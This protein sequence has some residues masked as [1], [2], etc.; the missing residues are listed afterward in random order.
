VFSATPVAVTG[1]P[2]YG[3]AVG[4]SHTC[5]L[6][7]WFGA[8]CWGRNDGGQLGN[9]LTTPLSSPT[10]VGLKSP[11]DAPLYPVTPKTDLERIQGVLGAAHPAFHL[12][13]A[14]LVTTGNETR[15][16]VDPDFQLL[17]LDGHELQAGTTL[18]HIPARALNPNWPARGQ[19][20][21]YRRFV[22]NAP[23]SDGWGANAFEWG[24]VPTL[25]LARES[26]VQTF[27]SAP[28][29]YSGASPSVALIGESIG[30]RTAILRKRNEARDAV[31]K[32][33]TGEG[34]TILYDAPTPNLPSDTVS[35]VCREVVAIAG[36]ART[37]YELTVVTAREDEAKTVAFGDQVQHAALKAL[38]P[39]ATV[40]GSGNGDLMATSRTTL[41]ARQQAEELELRTAQLLLKSPSSVFLEVSAVPREQGSFQ[42]VFDGAIRELGPATEFTVLDG[43][44]STRGGALNALAVESVEVHPTNWSM[45]RYDAYGLPI[46]WVPSADPSLLGSSG[47]EPYLYFLRLAEK[48]AR[49][50]TKAIE[51][52]AE[53]TRQ[54]EIDAQTLAAAQKKGAQLRAQENE[55]LCGKANC[56]DVKWSVRRPVGDIDSGCAQVTLPLGFSGL[57]LANARLSAIEVCE[58]RVQ[59]LKSMLERGHQDPRGRV[60]A[61]R[62]RGA[63]VR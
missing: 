55:L 46:D 45:P 1:G 20:F 18:R 2:Y 31:A 25:A 26:I 23:A 32:V 59:A 63:V 13:G 8:Q 39:S 27:G 35:G 16:H 11:G 37:A 30:A 40:L 48:T 19:G 56:A 41:T 28:S 58:V 33:C 60:G 7:D 4:G 57:N 61:A 54:E 21:L 44:I 36:G 51:D 3:V 43:A 6:S 10:A 17:T 47:E 22:V 34:V 5:A 52:A 53:V 29:F 9:G 15:I 50:A 42:L 62:P 14:E 38:D 49:E 12:Q 24:S